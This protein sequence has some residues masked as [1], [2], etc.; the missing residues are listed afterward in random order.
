MNMMKRLWILL[1][2]IAMLALPLTAFADGGVNATVQ[3]G[4][5][6]ITV[7]DVVP[8]QV[9]VTH[10]QGWRVLFPALDKTWGELEVRSQDAPQISQNANGTETTTQVI[11]VSRF[12][13][14]EVTTP[15][16]TLTVADDQGTVQTLRVQPV[17]LRVNSVLAKNDTKL[18]DIKPQAELW[19]FSNS[20]LPFAASLAVA[21]TLVGGAVTLAWKSRPVT[22]KRTPR[23]RALDELKSIEAANYAASGD[24][25][26]YS[27]RVSTV[28]RDY[29]Q[30]GCKLPAN[31][32]T[33]GELAQTMK[34]SQVPADVA[35]H[36]IQVLR[37]CDTVKF[38]N[39]VS[40][41]EAIQSLVAVTRKIVVEYPPAPNHTA[42]KREVKK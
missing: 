28:L 39:D 34:Q 42:E 40:D 7:G 3:V 13:P 19:Q 11:H 21:F 9:T 2:V 1:V 36:I 25:K 24:L 33:T 12:R 14:G 23:E 15:E 17:T 27:V 8:V 41:A 32:M 35:A 37:V 26:L 10:P 30:K 20:P 18:R 5:N 29:L 38:A 4:R 16:M 22:D 6:E 31:D